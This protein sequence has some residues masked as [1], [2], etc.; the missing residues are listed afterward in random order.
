MSFDGDLSALSEFI[1]KL[2]GFSGQSDSVDSDVKKLTKSFGELNKMIQTLNSTVQGFSG[3]SNVSNEF[4]EIVSVIER[5]KSSINSINGSG[6]GLK[7]FKND[8]T[9]IA[10][11]MEQVTQIANGFNATLTEVANKPSVNAR[12]ITTFFNQ[13][14]TMVTNVENNFRKL[15]SVSNEIQQMTTFINDLVSTFDSLVNLTSKY[16]SLMQNTSTPADATKTESYFRELITLI[17]RLNMLYQGLNAQVSSIQ[18]L[19]NGLNTLNGIMNSLVSITEQF[20][21]VLNNATDMPN[22][23]M[24]SVYFQQLMQSI[25]QVDEQFKK[26]IGDSQNLERLNQQFSGLAGIMNSMV[27]TAN[28]LDTALQRTA[29]VPSLDQLEQYFVSL[30]QLVA[31][32]DVEFQNF[33]GVNKDITQV[34]TTFRELSKIVTQLQKIMNKLGSEDDVKQ[35]EAHFKSLLGILRQVVDEINQM[36]INNQNFQQL[37]Q[38]LQNLTQTLNA[39]SQSQQAMSRQ[40]QTLTNNI[41]QTQVVTSGFGSVFA[42]AFGNGPLSML[43]KMHAGVNQV[44]FGIQGLIVALGGRALWDWLIGTNQQIEVLQTSLEVTLKSARAAEDA[45]RSL[46]SYAALTPFQ[47]LETFQAGEMLAANRMDID[48]WIRIAG[49]LASAKRTAG[50]ELNDVINVL[51]RV[52]S[53]D[54]GKAMIRLRQMGISLNDLREKGLEFSKNNTFLGDTDEFLSALETII[55]ERYGGLT[56]AL[57]Q[58]T[59]GLISTIKDF[60]LQVGIELGDQSFDR[61]QDWL[62]GVKEDLMDILDPTTE[63]GKRFENLV[64]DFNKFIDAMITFLKPFAETLAFLGDKLLYLLPAIA[65]LVQLLLTMKIV[66]SVLTGVQTIMT[67]LSNMGKNWQ[68]IN[69]VAAEQ[70]AILQQQNISLSQQEIQLAKINALR[71]MGN[72]LASEQAAKDTLSAEMTA[73]AGMRAT[74]GQG[75]AAGLGGLAAGLGARIPQIMMAVMALQLVG[76]ALSGLTSLFKEHQQ[77]L[78]ITAHDYD[79]VIGQE[80][81]E[82]KYIESLNAARQGAID[83]V[84]TYSEAQKEVDADTQ[85]LIYTEEQAAEISGR[86]SD[87]KNELSRIN[88]QLIEI[89]ASLGAQIVDSTGKLHD[90]T[91]AYELNTAAIERN[92][93]ARKGKIAQMYAEQVEAAKA[94][95]DLLQKEMADASYVENMSDQSGGRGVMAKIGEGANKVL[96]VLTLGSFNL[97]DSVLSSK[98]RM[99]MKLASGSA[100]ERQAYIDQQKVKNYERQQRIKELDDMIGE[101]AKARSAGYVTKDQNGNEVVDLEKYREAQKKEQEKNAMLRERLEATPQTFQNIMEDSKGEQERIARQWDIKLQNELIRNGNDTDGEVYKQLEQ[102]KAAALGQYIDQTIADIKEVYTRNAQGKQEQLKRLSPALRDLADADFTPDQIIQAVEIFRAKGGEVASFMSKYADQ[103]KRLNEDL[104]GKDPKFLKALL[105]DYDTFKEVKKAY[106]DV[107]A[108]LELDKKKE[109]VDAM[110]KAKKTTE[111]SAYDKFNDEWEK[112]RQMEELDKDL[113]LQRDELSGQDKDSLVYKT[114]EKQQNQE[115]VNFIY[116]EMDALRSLMNTPAFKASKDYERE[117]YEAQVQ[118]LKL[119]KE[120][121]SLLLEIKKNTTKIGEFNKPGFVRAITYYD[122]KAKDAKSTT[123]EIGDAKFIMQVSA[124]QTLDDVEKMWEL[125]KK[126][127]GD[128][129]KRTESSGVVNANLYT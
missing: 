82:V 122:Y 83:T 87:A 67:N 75:A 104:G 111:R 42:G 38:M 55:N 20:N 65:K 62:K 86:L 92:I 69:A 30:V 108:Q 56:T 80:I 70:I 76:T 29:N 116:Q 124:P 64:E 106:E 18:G 88:G 53:G 71:K 23:A 74:A 45:I 31:R 99:G 27:S 4:N 72:Q 39:A 50:V 43:E 21:T 100:E 22:G 81:E 127:F 58:T 101:E 52:N 9:N 110:S 28:S 117:R 123:M 5:M 78:I 95:K 32:L 112:K 15:L 37:N 90:E 1:Q 44:A 125:V 129:I 26:I 85:N 126:Y 109:Q 14:N 84:E 73:A 60:F 66:S 51:T 33:A 68:T 98:D 25:V 2:Q 47:E 120:A 79:R 63:V 34:V 17:E 6:N 12:E 59:E 77:E 35:M 54:F 48:K 46:R 49:D 128:Y 113:L 121:N 19:A 114:H 36:T 96:E 102:Q 57:G 16:N 7:T 89:D 3:M 8:V 94:E 61:L 115:I 103:I 24:L 118:L 105:T 41:R 97:Y 93:A 10:K 11:S 107:S 40:Q 119:E 91:G 13:L